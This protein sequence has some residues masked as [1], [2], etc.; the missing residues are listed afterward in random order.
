MTTERQSALVGRHAD[1]YNEQPTIEQLEQRLAEMRRERVQFLTALPAQAGVGSVPELIS[2]L[3]SIAPGSAP[4]AP[5][6]ASKK[7]QQQQ[8]RTKRRRGV[9]T[10]KKRLAILRVLAAGRSSKQK[11]ARRF[12]LSRG[13]IYAIEK[14]ARQTQLD[15]VQPPP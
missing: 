11:I 3:K 4:S 15:S 2:L 1:S 14:T 6:P 13:T 8:Q 10:P 7:Q 5:A 12:G 9:V